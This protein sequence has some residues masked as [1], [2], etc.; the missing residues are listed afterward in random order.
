[1][2]SPGGEGDHTK[3]KKKTVEVT[4]WT[5]INSAKGRERKLRRSIMERETR[6][7]G[8]VQC[9]VSVDHARVS[10]PYAKVTKSTHLH[11]R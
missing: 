3:G 5:L 11:P 6:G 4:V 7:G 2:R 1:M 8:G 10:E 9:W